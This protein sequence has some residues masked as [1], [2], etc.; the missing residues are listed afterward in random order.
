M[1]VLVCGDRNWTDEGAIRQE[2][3][4]LPEDAVVIH[5]ACRGADRLAGQIAQE[6]DLSFE[7]YPANWEKFGKAAGPI[8]N[9]QML[10]SG[11]DLVLAFHTD[12]SQSRGTAHMVRIAS[13]AGI[14]VRVFDGRE[15]G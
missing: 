3:A 11:L 10:L 9:E 13:Y 2:L 4:K 14:E 1:R 6:L 7:E 5:G 8:R 12:L 15:G